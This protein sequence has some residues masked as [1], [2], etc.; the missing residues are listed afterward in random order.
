M[1][2][3]SSTPFVFL[4]MA[5]LILRGPYVGIALLAA[6]MPF[7]MT[8]AFNL[9]AVGGTSILMSDLLLLTLLVLVLLRK[10]VDRDITAIFAPGG[11]ALTL[12]LFLGYTTLASVFLPRVYAGMTEVFS[13]SRLV[14]EEGI[15]SIPLQASGANL[16]QLIRLCFSL[17]SFLVVAILIYRRPNPALLLRSMKLATGINVALGLID[18][19]SANAGMASIMDP[20]RTA[21]YALTLGQEMAG[22]R[23]MIG[24]FPE[25]STFGYF[26][27]GLFGFWMSYYLSSRSA[28][29]SGAGLWLALATFALLRC[30]SSSAYVGA[31]GFLAVFAIVQSRNATVG[32][33][34][35]AAG[36]VL[37]VAAL[38]PV[39]AAASYVAYELIP[40]VTQ[41]VDRSLFDKLSS[42]SGIERMSWNAQ[43]IKNFFD[44]DM[45]G[46]GLGSVRAS[47]WITA[48]LASVGLPGFFMLLV[49]YKRLFMAPNLSG[50]P[51]TRRIVSAMKMGCLAFIMRSL[52]VHGTP[53]MGIMFFFMAGSVAGF[54][55]LA[56]SATAHSG[57]PTRLMTRSVT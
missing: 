39:L 55:A 50:D 51:E 46:A 45:L 23:R 40:A 6:L 2:I 25:A 19:T 48:A 4:M 22:V 17:T 13:L 7:G 54:A 57:Q 9:P 29:Q 16:S 5:L 1:Q 34:R 56:A 24:G 8:A 18:V 11:M 36:I 28:G 32:M 35:A 15:I 33:S 52:V 31:A 37:V 30:T 14:N 20:F 53:N 38:I 27:L 43:A 42:N 26:S 21:N 3:V 41:F 44:T 49:F 47:N 12:L 10:G